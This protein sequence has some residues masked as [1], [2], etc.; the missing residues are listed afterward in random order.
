MVYIIEMHVCKMNKTPVFIRYAA[1]FNASLNKQV[2]SAVRPIRPGEEV[3]ISF[4]ETKTRDADEEEE[5][6][7]LAD[8]AYEHAIRN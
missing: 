1:V 6:D 3:T 7:R 2:L 4:P 8:M 5:I